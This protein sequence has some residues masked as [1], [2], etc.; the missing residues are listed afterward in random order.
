[1]RVWARLPPPTSPGNATNAAGVTA[2]DGRRP[3]TAGHCGRRPRGA[4]FPGAAPEPGW[5]RTQPGPWGRWPTRRCAGEQ[6]LTTDLPENA[7]G[8]AGVTANG[9]LRRRKRPRGP[10]S[11]GRSLSTYQQERVAAFSRYIGA[12][13]MQDA[14]YVL[15]VKRGP[16]GLPRVALDPLC[17]YA[18][19][20]LPGCPLSRSGARPPASKNGRLPRGGTIRE[21]P[22]LVDRLPDKAFV[23]REP[24]RQVGPRSVRRS[25]P[26]VADPPPAAAHQVIESLARSSP[27][28]IAQH[29]GGTP[30]GRESWILDR[31]A[32]PRPFASGQLPCGPPTCATSGRST[33]TRHRAP[34]SW[35]LDCPACGRHARWPLRP[36]HLARRPRRRGPGLAEALDVLTTELAS[37]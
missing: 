28:G 19:A 26:P 36:R 30:S 33:P 21:P 27:V 2:R 14:P 17:G 35:R 31:L 37:Y 24:L 29:P 10:P 12:Q 4:F 11:R 3:A 25:R 34:T 5:R 23:Q 7:S 32:L 1:M 13:T 8:A 15:V 6:H 16:R 18:Q 9:D 22:A 20:R